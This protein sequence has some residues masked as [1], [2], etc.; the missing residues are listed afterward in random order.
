GIVDGC[1]V[2]QLNGVHL[3]LLLLPKGS[4]EAENHAIARIGT[5][6]LRQTRDPEDVTPGSKEVTEEELECLLR[7]IVQDGSWLVQEADNVSL[8][9]TCWG[10][11]FMAKDSQLDIAA[12]GL[13]PLPH[14]VD[15]WFF[16]TGTEKSDR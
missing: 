6:D 16:L 2:V 10:S 9:V 1:L 11:R 7:H 13:E 15:E 12:T 3:G 4:S 5:V 14:R 8:V